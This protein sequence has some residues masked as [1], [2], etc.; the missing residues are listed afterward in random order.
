[1]SKILVVGSANADLMIATPK[2]PNPG[3]TVRGHDFLVAPGGKGANQAIAAARLGGDVGFIGSIGDDDFGRSIKKSLLDSGVDTARLCVR[4]NSATGVALIFSEACGE[5]MIVI[6]AGANDFLLPADID[7]AADAIAEASIIVCQF[8]S[9]VATIERLVTVAKLSGVPVLL[10][11]A[12]ARRMADEMVDGIRFLVPNR[13]E[14]AHLTG[15]PTRTLADVEAAAKALLVRGAESVIVTLG[16]EGVLRASVAGA[17]V[18]PA[19]IVE[20]VDTTGAG[21]T[22][23]GGF[24]A[25]WCRTSDVDAAI[26]FAQRAAA[27]SVTGRGA[28]ASMPWLSDLD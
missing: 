2:L 24:A 6:A 22:F 13:Q 23:V 17:R 3:E 16:R 20:A 10:N 27:Y 19:P 28:Q 21:D 26:S 8:E 14:L 1:M 18:F 11:P 25:E 7:A 15:L 9:P 4:P 5:N 12:P